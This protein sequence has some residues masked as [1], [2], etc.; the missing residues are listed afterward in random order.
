MKLILDEKGKC[1]PDVS[2][3]KQAKHAIETNSDFHIATLDAFRAEMIK[4]PVEKR[5]QVE[6]IIY[7]KKVE[8]NEDMRSNTAWNDKRMS[9]TENNLFDFLEA[10]VKK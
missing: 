7:G 3:N 8:F 5:P 2:M 9:I 4:I 6:Y 10:M 1:Y